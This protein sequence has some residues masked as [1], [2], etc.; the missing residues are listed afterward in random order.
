MNL[1]IFRH[2]G[3][4][5]RLPF[6]QTSVSDRY[7][8]IHSFI[9]YTTS[10]S[11]R[12]FLCCSNRM[13]SHSEKSLIQFFIFEWVDCIDR[14]NK[15]MINFI[16]TGTFKLKKNKISIAE[17]HNGYGFEISWKKQNFESFPFWHWRLFEKTVRAKA[18]FVESGRVALTAAEPQLTTAEGLFN[19]ID[20]PATKGSPPLIFDAL[21][22]CFSQTRGLQKG[23]QNSVI[24]RL[25]VPST[26]GP[27]TVDNFDR[28]HPP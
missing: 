13:L 2:H 22:K 23:I 27:W 8:F 9:L 19:R 16:G 6:T 1:Y 5:W 24:S 4:H 18:T 21:I 26:Q 25:T 17:L 3:H 20:R 12:E 15:S 7:P 14:W 11:S 10:L 28:P